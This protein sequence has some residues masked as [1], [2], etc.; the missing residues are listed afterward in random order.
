MLQRGVIS[1]KGE[2][3]NKLFKDFVWSSRFDTPPRVPDLKIIAFDL[4]TGKK[5]N[6]CLSFGLFSISFKNMSLL[7]STEHVLP[8]YYGT[9]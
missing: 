3:K 8:W 4:D 5:T 6:T 7:N 1:E 9:R 2:W